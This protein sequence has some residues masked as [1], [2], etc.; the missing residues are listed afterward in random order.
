MATIPQ[1]A[2]DFLE[3]GLFAHVTTLNP[4]GT[5]HISLAWAGFDG[6]GAVFSSF[7]DQHKIDNIRRDPRVSLSFNAREFEGEGL[8]PYLVIRG[9]GRVSEGGALE[10]MDRLAGF[11]LGPGEKY[12]WRDPPPG[13]VVH[14]AID[15]IYG[16]GP[17]HAEGQ[18]DDQED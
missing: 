14:I 13:V 9:R 15:K 16:Q 3:G 18:E 7:F 2:R 11:Y 6:D 1:S 12:P 5:P 8:W 17:W 10:V 4:D